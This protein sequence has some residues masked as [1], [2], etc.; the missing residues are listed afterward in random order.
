MIAHEAEETGRYEIL[1]VDDTPD[2]LRFLTRILTDH[3]YKVRPASG[4]LLALR[5]TAVKT[6]D[7]ILLDVKMPDMDGFEVCRRLKADER[8]RDIPVLFISAMGEIAEKAKGFEAGGV[9]YITKPFETDEVLAR[10]GIHLR[11]HE[12]NERLEQK[13]NERTGELTDANRKLRQEIAG[14]QLAETALKESE[15]R[16]RKLVENIP[17]RIFIKDR[18]SVYIDSNLS[19][20]KDR[21]IEE[22]EIRGKTDYDFYPAELAEKYRAEDRRIMDAG[23]EEEMENMHT[24]DGQDYWIQVIKIPLSDEA[25]MVTGVLGVYW[26]ITERKRS[27]EAIRLNNFR[28]QTLLKLNQMNDATLRQITDFALE[29]AVRITKSKIGYLSFLNDDETILTMHSWSEQA[30]KESGIINKPIEYIVKDMSLWGEAIRQRRPIITND[31]AAPSPLKK[32]QQAGH[33]TVRRHMNVPVFAGEH[34]VIVAGVG[35]KDSDYDENDVQQLTLLM[36]GT[37]RLIEHK[38]AEEKIIQSLREKETLIRELY[39]RTKNTMQVIH[40]MLALQAADYPANAELQRVMKNTEDRIEVI[41]LVHQ[42]LYNSQDLSRISIKEY[43]H[44]LSSLIMRSYGVSE[45]RIALNTNIDD[46]YFLLDTAIPFGL[47]LNELMTNSLKYAF[48]GNRKGIITITLTRGESNKNTLRY[49]DNGVGVPA[50]FIFPNKNTLGMQLI[51]SI[52]EQQLMGEVVMEN[53]NGV[54]CI[55]EFRNNLYK[56]RV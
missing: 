45:D 21:G 13:V 34:I 11:L 10:I 20:A 30:I 47:I 28:M 3:G 56:V 40:G 22:E 33:V 1:V 32:G 4:G 5:S 19:Y 12:L 48:P 41:S 36:E 17:V 38:R 35:N 49:S 53:N 25:H 51:Y 46:Q 14:H 6:P 44:E 39:H 15:Q 8:N 9:D 42:M 23:R 54:S 43:I 29:G 27:E 52:S 16:F 31:Y 18:E 24:E 26:D 50:G 2:N 55:F 37:W 7:L